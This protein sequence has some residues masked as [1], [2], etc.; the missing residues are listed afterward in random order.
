MCGSVVR[1]VNCGG[2]CSGPVIMRGAD[3]LCC[4][5]KVNVK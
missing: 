3:R 5:E 2:V 1:C 4:K